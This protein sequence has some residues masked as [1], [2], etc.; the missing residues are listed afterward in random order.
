MYDQLK[1]TITD[2]I[3]TLPKLYQLHDEI[4][5]SQAMDEY[6]GFTTRLLSQYHHLV[7]KEVEA[8][9]GLIQN[10]TSA[11]VNV[12]KEAV[13][14]VKACQRLGDF[15]ARQFPFRHQDTPFQRLH[16]S[17]DIPRAISAINRLTQST[18]RTNTTVPMEDTVSNVQ[19]IDPTVQTDLMTLINDFGDR[20]TSQSASIL[21]H[22]GHTFPQSPTNKECYAI[23]SHIEA[24][25]EYFQDE[26]DQ[27]TKQ[28][29]DGNIEGP[30][31]L[32]QCESFTRLLCAC[33]DM[34]QD[35]RTKLPS[36]LKRYISTDWHK[37]RKTLKL[38]SNR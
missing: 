32:E 10:L 1:S 37:A 23:A 12:Q 13:L 11:S 5:Q 18:Q 15:W 29:V 6:L 4:S 30:D 16:E 27:V 36:G 25:C 35:W 38:T 33:T 2:M 21:G 20:V 24:L 34:A 22:A 17:F 8:R 3:V 14:D 7:T 31:C 28:L 19:E 9:V 26:S